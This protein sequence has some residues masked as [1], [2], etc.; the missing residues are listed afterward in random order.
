MALKQMC[1]K[2]S[3]D[4]HFVIDTQ[5]VRALLILNYTVD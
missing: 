3:N 5:C 2:A 1:V 4:V